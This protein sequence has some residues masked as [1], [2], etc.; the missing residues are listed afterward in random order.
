[1]SLSLRKE[2]AGAVPIVLKSQ[3]GKPFRI[4]S[5]D[6]TKSI[7][8]AAFDSAKEDTEFV[9]TPKIDIEKLQNQNNG[10]IN[11]KLTHPNCPQVSVKFAAVAEYE[12]SPKALIVR[13]ANASEPVEREIWITSNYAED[14][15]IESI[16]SEKGNI[17]VL[18][19]EKSQSRYQIKI[20]IVPP[21]R[22][23]KLLFFSDVLAINIKDF[24]PIKINCR[25]F[26]TRD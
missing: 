4:K 11:F 14:F 3:D 9:I 7:V 18:K 2:N 17:K 13:K 25:G 24:G 22:Q 23:G 8:S 12:V 1:M 20:Q 10:I 26:Y 15:Q 19:T 21:P 16:E 6:S 5:M